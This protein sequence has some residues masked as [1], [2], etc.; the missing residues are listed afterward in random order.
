MLGMDV[1]PKAR[2]KL[3]GFAVKRVE[4]GSDDSGCLPNFLLFKA[5]DEGADSD[6]STWL[7]PGA[8]VPVVR[9]RGTARA[10]LRLHGHAMYKKPS[11]LR[12]DGNIYLSDDDSWV[13]HFFVDGTPKSSES[14]LFS[15]SW[16]GR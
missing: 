5:N 4:E 14:L 12:A 10:V 7:K 1:D 11:K 8:D 2:P 13:A 6:H 16:G 15:G 9:L 3:M